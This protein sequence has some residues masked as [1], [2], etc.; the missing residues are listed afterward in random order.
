MSEP[1]IGEIQLFGFNF[2][3]RGWAFCNGATLAISQNTALFALLG[4]NYGGDGRTTFK[5]PNFAGRA[6]CQGGQGP[7]LSLRDLGQTFG[8]NTVSLTAPQMPQ[9]AHGLN[10]YTQPDPSK[11]QSVPAGNSALAT[12]ASTSTTAFAVPPANSSFLPAM[13][14]PSG[15]GALPHENQQPYLAVNFSIALQGIFPSFP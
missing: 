11:R 4:T 9:H 7:G 2:S 3:P 8:A 12:P 13:L 14:S 1:F 6:G 15:G 5:L 10:I